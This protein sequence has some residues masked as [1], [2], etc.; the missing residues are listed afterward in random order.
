[1]LARAFPW[2]GTEAQIGCSLG[3]FRIFLKS[4][5]YGMV[6][7]RQQILKRPLGKLCGFFSYPDRVILEADIDRDPGNSIKADQPEASGMLLTS[8][9]RRL[10]Q[11]LR[12]H[13]GRKTLERFI[14]EMEKRAR[15]DQ[16]MMQDSLSGTGD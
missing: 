14:Q 7:S 10:I 6:L 3:W 16:E 11:L 15:L 12:D 2:G 1:M 9:E 13:G 8:E 4:K 5:V